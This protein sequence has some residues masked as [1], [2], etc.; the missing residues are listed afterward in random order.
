VSYVTVFQYLHVALQL[1]S[2]LCF[3]ARAHTHTHTHTHATHY[4]L[5]S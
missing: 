2:Y 1:D 4:S 3:S 5:T